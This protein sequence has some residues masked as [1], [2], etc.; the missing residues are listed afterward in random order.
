[1]TETQGVGVNGEP[2]DYA[3][4]YDRMLVGRGSSAWAVKVLVALV[5]LVAASA[6]VWALLPL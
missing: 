5:A 3:A 4:R 6:A 2:D 1:M